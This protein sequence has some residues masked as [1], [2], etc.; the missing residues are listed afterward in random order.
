M[1]KHKG[2]SDAVGLNASAT[3]LLHR[4]LRLALDFHAEAAGEGAVTQRQLTVLAAAGAASGL[5]QNDLVRATGIDRSTLAELVAR[6]LKRG[7]LERRRSAT[8]A[9]ANTVSLSAAGR[10]ALAA[11]AGPSAAA[12]ARLL[13]LLSPKKRETFLKTLNA[14]A[15]AADQPAKTKAAKPA[16]PKKKKHK[17]ARKTRDVGA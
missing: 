13:G 17:K 3:H 10:S 4:A 6:M 11:G 5:T 7:L 14:L 12:D 16:K 15:T 8:D 9:R 2:K 1:A